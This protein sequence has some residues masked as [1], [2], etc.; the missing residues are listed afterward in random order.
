MAPG[1]LEQVTV[2]RRRLNTAVHRL[3]GDCELL[4][5]DLNRP[6]H[7]TWREQ[8]GRALIQAR[9][10]VTLIGAG[11]VTDA[12]S[13]PGSSLASSASNARIASLC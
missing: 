4:L 1:E 11:R 6:T 8:A 2:A 13:V 10:A 7:H 3:A 5:A 9:Y 12:P